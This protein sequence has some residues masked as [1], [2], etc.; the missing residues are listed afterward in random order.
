MLGDGG[1]DQLLEMCLERCKGRRLVLLHESAVAD[2]ISGQDRGKAALDAFFGHWL[3]PF[4][5]IRCK[6]LRL[7]CRA[8]SSFRTSAPGQ[9]ERPGTTGTRLPFHQKRTYQRPVA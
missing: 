1:E 5:K 3:R 9:P 8:V 7:A 4:Q 6:I 2:H